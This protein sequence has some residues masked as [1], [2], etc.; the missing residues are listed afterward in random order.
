MHT[1]YVGFFDCLFQWHGFC[2]AEGEGCHFY[3]T[4]N[5]FVIF[6]F[7]QARYMQQNRHLRELHTPGRTHD[8]RSLWAFAQDLL[9]AVV[10]VDVISIVSKQPN[11]FPEF[12]AYSTHT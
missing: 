6:F 3:T 11:V 9:A 1:S 8:I 4:V 5:G 10:I 7:K 12:E 2:G